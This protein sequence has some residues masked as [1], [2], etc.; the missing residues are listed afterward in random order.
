MK[1][2]LLIEDEE[3]VRG[4]ISQL[5]RN[6]NYETLEADNGAVGLQLAC[7]QKPDL[8]LCDVNM[9]EMDGHSVLKGLR[10]NPLTSSTPFIFLTGQGEKEDLR[11]GMNSGADDYLTKPIT[12]EELRNAISVRLNRRAEIA[13][14]YTHELQ[15]AEEKMKRLIYYDTLTDLPNRMMISDMM[16]EMLKSGSPELAVLCLT[17]DRF[18]Q[19]ND[20]LGYYEGDVMLTLL[21]ERLRKCLRHENIIARISQDEFAI[22]VKGNRKS[23]EQ[24]ATRLLHCIEKPFALNSY[25]V[26][27]TA[28]IGVALYQDDGNQIDQLLKKACTAAE[29]ARRNGGNQYVFSSNCLDLSSAENLVMENELRLAMERSE[30]DVHYQPQIDVKTGQIVGAESLMRWCHPIKGM[31]SPMKFIP[32]AEDSGLIL[33]LGEWILSMA[34]AHLKR[35]RKESNS[36]FR[37]AVNLSGCQFKRPDIGERLMAILRGSGVDPRDLELEITESVLIQNP[38]TALNRLKELKTLGVQISLDDFGTG[39]SSFTYLKQFPFDTVKIDRSFISG[40]DR[41]SKNG[42]IVTAIIQMARSLNL[43][44]I[45][46]G[47]ETQQEYEFLKLHGCD[48]VQGYL[49][50][51]PVPSVKFHELFGQSYFVPRPE[52]VR[53]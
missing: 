8:V 16:Q 21:A 31:I 47:V 40:V 43:K 30:M 46:E 53:H 10:S 44:I 19:V 26:Y 17:L 2:I 38:E 1:K 51:P 22:L 15:L 18:K 24:F 12:M 45:A 41:D 23:A 4:A 52:E 34:C 48:E 35:W 20:G 39:Y 32:V 49:F 13:Q 6:M 25:E 28:S 9:P 37:V 36:R 14:H 29:H 7:E 42:A 33:P 50:S 11:R 3:F 5:L 27:L